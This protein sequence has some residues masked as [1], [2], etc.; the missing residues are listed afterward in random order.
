MCKKPQVL[1]GIDASDKERPYFV[2]EV[3]FLEKH[4]IKHTFNFSTLEAAKLKYRS[5]KE[6]AK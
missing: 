5:I 4:V 3:R 1:M 6:P 2:Q